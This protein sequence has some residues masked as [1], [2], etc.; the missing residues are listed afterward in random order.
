ML[1]GRQQVSMEKNSDLFSQ[2]LSSLL[3]DFQLLE[4]DLWEILGLRPG[5]MGSVSCGLCSPLNNRIV[6]STLF[7]KID[8]GAWR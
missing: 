1:T 7:L 4:R 3:T 2:N 6:L 8:D 5:E